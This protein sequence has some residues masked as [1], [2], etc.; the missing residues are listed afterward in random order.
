M[1]ALPE[2]VLVDNN[3]RELQELDRQLRGL[4]R[5]WHDGSLRALTKAVTLCRWYNCP[6]PD[7]AAQ[8]VLALIADRS[9]AFWRGNQTHEEWEQQ[10]SIH[11][12][13][14]ELVSELRARKEENPTDPLF[15]VV[16]PTWDAAYERVSEQLQRTAAA[17]SPD[18]IKKSY[19]LVERVF[20]TAKGSTRGWRFLVDWWGYW[21]KP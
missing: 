6:L 3:V 7:W 1:K 14:W 10:N 17:G 16:D 13:R 11:A 5:A 15:Q 12:I 19:Q 4:E 9:K 21:G 2:T 8:A 18:A 20:R